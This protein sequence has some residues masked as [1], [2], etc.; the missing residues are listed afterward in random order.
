MNELEIYNSI[1]Q[2]DASQKKQV[3]DYVHSLISE[4]KRGTQGKDLLRFAGIIQKEDIEI[5]S[6]AIEQD[7]ESINLNE[8]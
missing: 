5:I 4:K 2:L 6:R 1:N 7:C 3:L 8:W